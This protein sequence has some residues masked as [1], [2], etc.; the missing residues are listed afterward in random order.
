MDREAMP[1]IDA[2]HEAWHC[3]ALLEE[4]LPIAR[5]TLDPPRTYWGPPEDERTE[6]VF[7]LVPNLVLPWHPS[8]QD[9]GVLNRLGADVVDEARP[10]AEDLADAIDPRGVHSIAEA[11]LAAPA[12][13]LDGERIA[14]IYAEAASRG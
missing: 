11:L 2:L 5:V 9:H 1:R 12:Q 10:T 14:H 13:E 6:A 3:A 4:G 8:A 7:M